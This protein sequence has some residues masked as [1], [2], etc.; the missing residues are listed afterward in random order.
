MTTPSWSS[1][2]GMLQK[3]SKT[4][5]G[6]LAEGLQIPVTTGPNGLAWGRGLHSNIEEEPQKVEGDGRSPAGIFR[7][8]T[9]FGYH[10]KPLADVRLRYRQATGRDYFVD[11]PESED[12]NRWVTLPAGAANAPN[13]RWD[14]FER[15]RRDDSLYEFGIVI[16]HNV[17]PVLKGYGSA[18]F[19]H[20]WQQPGAP[21]AGCTAMAR[22]DL[23]ELMRWLDPEKKPVIIQIPQ[24]EL[25]RVK[26]K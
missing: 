24:N 3:Y 20:I 22:S 9:A 13:A 15:M 18:I 23:L 7:L 25:H 12:Y 21:T 17:A 5:D 19:F 6:W 1:S 16:L 26:V 10:A 4:E 2:A 11:D 14:S 8:G